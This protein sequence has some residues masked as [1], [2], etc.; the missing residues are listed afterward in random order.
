M[1][2]TQEQ[3]AEANKMARWAVFKVTGRFD[4]DLCQEA[5]VVI[6]THIRKFDPSMGYAF[7]TFLGIRAKGAVLDALRKEKTMPRTVHLARDDYPVND[8]ITI[9]DRE[10][11]VSRMKLLSQKD[12]QFLWDHYIG[13]VEWKQ[14]AEERG[15]SQEA[16]WDH[17]ARLI[18]RLNG[19]GT[20]KLISA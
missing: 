5:W 13:G 9:D 1:E 18:N 12:R 14:M 16:I 20:R 4:E 10:I 11:V 3:L 8:Q 2:P 7:S 6:M 15:V 17:R 19:H